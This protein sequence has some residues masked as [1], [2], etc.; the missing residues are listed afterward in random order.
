MNPKYCQKITI[1]RTFR[2]YCASMVLFF[3]SPW[4]PNCQKPSSESLFFFV[5]LFVCLMT[6]TYLCVRVKITVKSWSWGHSNPQFHTCS[7]ISSH[8][9]CVQNFTE[10]SLNPMGPLF[11]FRI[12]SPEVFVN[13]NFCLFLQLKWETKR[14]PKKYRDISIEKIVSTK[15]LGRNKKEINL[16]K[17]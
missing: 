5:V 2:L 13:R 7:D 10:L 1:Q 14:R 11:L 12:Y 8:D 9:T 4:R 15:C 17:W 6:A 16:S 3:S